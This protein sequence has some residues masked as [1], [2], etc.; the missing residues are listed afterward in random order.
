MRS[1]SLDHTSSIHALLLLFFSSLAVIS[2]W[3]IAAEDADVARELG[4]VK[5]KQLKELSGMAA[6]RQNPDI[7]WLH[8]DGNA[9]LVFAVSTSGQLAALVS[10]PVEIEDFEDIAIGPGPKTGTDYLYLGDIGDNDSKRDEIR[11]VRFAEPQVS[12]ARG[13]QIEVE[14][15]EVFRLKYPDG[16]HNAEALIV[17]PSSGDLFIVTK[18]MRN[19]RLFTCPASRLKDKASAALEFL[20]TLDI[21][22]VS[23]G[24]I[25]RDGSRIILRREDKGWLW[26]R[27]RG[28]SI[29]AALQTTPQEIAVR[30]SRQG[31][32]GEAVAFSPNGQRYYTVSEGKNQVICSFQ[33][34][35]VTADPSP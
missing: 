31:R 3:V 24:A 18:D 6:S 2:T 23:G 8:N 19:A 16:A 27:S 11:V 28:Q 7:L 21:H 12:E 30:G 5:P 10:W 22:D 4:K 26:N 29:A 35:A 15:A 9:R 25:A 1:I 20:G 33:L 14:A 17:D 13:G 32:N 34:P